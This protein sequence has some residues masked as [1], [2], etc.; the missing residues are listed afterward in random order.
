MTEYRRQRLEKVVQEKTGN[1][2]GVDSDDINL[3]IARLPMNSNDIPKH[4]F[5]LGCVGA[6]FTGFIA[7]KA[8]E[9]RVLTPDQRFILLWCM[10]LTSAFF[11]GSFHGTITAISGKNT[12][13]WAIA[14]TGGFAVWVLSYVFLPRV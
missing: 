1:Q 8:F 9:A 10:P 7:I 11:A 5:R 14:A 3:R 12:N 13:P 6:L 2:R 4:F